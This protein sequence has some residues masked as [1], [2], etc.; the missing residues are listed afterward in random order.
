M[1]NFI[2]LLFMNEDVF[3]YF[4]VFQLQILYYRKNICYIIKELKQLLAFMNSYYHAKNSLLHIF[5]HATQLTLETCQS[6]SE[7]TTFFDLTHHNICQSTFNFHKFV[8]TCK[9]SGSF[10]ILFDVVDLKLLPSN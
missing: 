5:H 6:M 3:A 8:S 10:I 7:C 9:N 1:A 4:C 2:Y